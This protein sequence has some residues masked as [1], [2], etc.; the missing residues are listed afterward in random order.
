[1]LRN[2]LS[3]LSYTAGKEEDFRKPS[4]ASEIGEPNELEDK[5]IISQTVRNF[6]AFGYGTRK[7]FL[8]LWTGL[9][10]VIM[11]KTSSELNIGSGREE[12]IDSMVDA[13]RGLTVL[14]MLAFRKFYSEKSS[15]GSP[16]L[17][18]LQSHSRCPLPRVLE[19]EPDLSASLQI[20]SEWLSSDPESQG[21]STLSNGASCSPIYFRKQGISP[22]TSARSSSSGLEVEN[23]EIS[24]DS[25]V[26][27]LNSSTQFLFDL[28]LRWFHFAIH[29]N[30]E[31]FTRLYID[32]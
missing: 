28:F 12:E 27:D 14:T 2:I 24:S 30:P 10:Q 4:F 25:W 17:S 13:V 8:S 11:S 29:E 6:G 3:I 9:Q 1:V 16:V 18:P 22:M 26:P 15:A 19:A 23:T 20:S 5:D 21:P 32:F 31:G 7:C